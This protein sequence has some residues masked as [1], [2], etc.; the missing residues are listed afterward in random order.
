MDT[1]KTFWAK[2]L[3]RDHLPTSHDRWADP[4]IQTDVDLHQTVRAL[5]TF[6]VRFAGAIDRRPAHRVFATRRI[7]RTARPI[8][9]RHL[10]L[11]ANRDRVTEDELGTE[12]RVTADRLDRA[13]RLRGV[14]LFHLDRIC[15]AGRERFALLVSF[16]KP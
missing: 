3:T 1:L 6:A 10:V 7:L 14:A 2:L 11:F 16:A 8:H 4:D 13:A 9:V 5:G 15:G 12:D